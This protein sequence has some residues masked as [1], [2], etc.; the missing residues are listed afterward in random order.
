MFPLYQAEY[1]S[2]TISTEIKKILDTHNAIE[3]Y[4]QYRQLFKHFFIFSECFWLLDVGLFLFIF[5][6]KTN[7]KSKKLNANLQKFEK[8]N[9]RP[10][11]KLMPKGQQYLKRVKVF[12]VTGI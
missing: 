7:D 4:R 1:Q 5:L 8:T 3:C 11:A 2:T 10:H 6:V 9:K 12:Y